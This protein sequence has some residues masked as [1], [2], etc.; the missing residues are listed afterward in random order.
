LERERGLTDGKTAGPVLQ[1]SGA[2]GRAET[3]R[4]NGRALRSKRDIEK[5]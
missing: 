5:R 2:T 4:V 3:L 1:F